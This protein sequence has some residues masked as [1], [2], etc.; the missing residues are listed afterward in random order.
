MEPNKTTKPLSQGQ[1]ILQV[2]QRSTFRSCICWDGGF[3]GIYLVILLNEIKDIKFFW[4]GWCPGPLSLFTVWR[5]MGLDTLFPYRSINEQRVSR[6]EI[7]KLLCLNNK[8]LLSFFCEKS[9]KIQRKTKKFRARPKFRPGLFLMPI[10][11]GQTM[12]GFRE[13]HC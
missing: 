13:C 6:N 12:P 3:R 10:R 8:K 9:R 7:R 4:E 1:C 5:L 2:L 11:P